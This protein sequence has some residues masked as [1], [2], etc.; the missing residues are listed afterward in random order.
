M[1]VP[2]RRR[3]SKDQRSA[4]LVKIA[5]VKKGGGVPLATLSIKVRV[6]HLGRSTCYAISGQGD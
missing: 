3:F 1:D 5:E 4:L 2:E 6:V